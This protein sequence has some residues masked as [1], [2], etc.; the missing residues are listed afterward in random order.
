MVLI[1][2]ADILISLVQNYMIYNFMYK[3]WNPKYGYIR[4]NFLTLLAVAGIYVN[5]AYIMMEAPMPMRYI[6]G[7]SV[8]LLYAVFALDG[9]V[10]QNIKRGI[11][12]YIA[13]ASVEIATIFFILSPLSYVFI[14]SIFDT[15][16]TTNLVIGRTIY[17]FVAYFFIMV[18]QLVI[19]WKKS[20]ELKLLVGISAILVVCELIFLF[21]LFYIVSENGTKYIVMISAFASAIVML[22]YYLM[23]EMF[24]EMIR[25][26]EKKSELEQERLEQKYQYDYYMLAREQGESARDLR[27]DM[28]NQLQTVQYL[29]QAEN[30]EDRRRAEE[31]L[32][33]LRRKIER[34][35]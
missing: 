3:I 34:V 25:Q 2:I 28:R 22:G 8:M 17:T 26:Q 11:L 19:N 5:G 31:M 1:R 23:T 7:I 15:G 33:K 6:C 9:T 10:L 21:V 24:Y 16:F 20:R 12:Y 18:I 32:E 29:M 35:T 14:N 4:S 30:E 13:L 27:H